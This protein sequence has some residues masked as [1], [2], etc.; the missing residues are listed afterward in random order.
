[1]GLR[2]EN[3]PEE[4]NSRVDIRNIYSSESSRESK[5]GK[6]RKKKRLPA[7]GAPTSPDTLDKYELAFCTGIITY[8]ALIN[9]S[10]IKL[11]SVSGFDSGRRL[12][13]Q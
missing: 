12:L 11:A 3:R 9:R 1:M 13:I 4:L 5:V 6:S 2:A 8:T 10:V 7:A